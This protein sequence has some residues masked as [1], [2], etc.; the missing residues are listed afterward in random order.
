[1]S[2]VRKRYNARAVLARSCR[3]ILKTNHA[4][5]ANVQP[6][7]KQIM[8]DWKHC[9]Q[10][11]SAPVA[12]A[13]CDIAHHWTIYISVFCQK[14]DGSQYS[15]SMEFSTDGMHLVANLEQV[16][17]DEHAA[18]VAQSNAN[19]RIGSGWIAIPDKTS[20]T[21]EQANRVFSAMGVWSRAVA[22]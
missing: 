21:E 1:M 3:A 4:A 17:M 16:M 14:P 18:L 11:R 20:L 9:K 12:D 7:D 22:A 8:I 2:K 19:H 6:P 5:I 15:K 10:I 13:L